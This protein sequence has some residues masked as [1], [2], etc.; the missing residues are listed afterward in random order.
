[1]ISEVL[2][3]TP[4]PPHIRIPEYYTTEPS[5]PSIP[6]FAD[7]PTR[8]DGT[9]IYDPKN[10]PRFL[11]LA[12]RFIANNDSLSNKR[13]ETELK[14]LQTPNLEPTFEVKFKFQ[15]LKPHPVFYVAKI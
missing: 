11:I 4:V 3:P 7:Y 13:K 5:R 9:T 2:L 14:R 10:D 6:N 12:E 1:M 8:V 15:G